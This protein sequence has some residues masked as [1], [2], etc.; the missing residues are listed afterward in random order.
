MLYVQRGADG[1]I[2]ALFQKKRRGAGEAC[3]PDHPD[4]VA[5]LSDSGAPEG[6]GD[7][8]NNDLAMARVVE[9]LIDVLIGKGMITLTD[10]PLRAQHKLVSRHGKRD[11]LGFVARLYPPSEDDELG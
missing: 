11:D 6:R 5:F 4:V 8:A 7:W 3:P 10:L 1:R 9:D 2:N